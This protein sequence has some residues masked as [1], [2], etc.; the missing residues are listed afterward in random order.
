[1]L[2]R[3]V[4]YCVAIGTIAGSLLRPARAADEGVP[5]E[6]APFSDLV[7]KCEEF[8]KKTHP[9]HWG[10]LWSEDFNK[11]QADRWNVPPE[12]APNLQ[13]IRINAAPKISAETID[14]RACAVLDSTGMQGNYLRLGPMVHDDFAIEF[15]GQAV[16]DAICDLSILCTSL[17]RGPAFQFG[18]T[19]NTRNVL[20]Y[21]AEGPIP[22]QVVLADKP[23]IEKGRWYTVRLEVKKGK[24]RGLVDGKLFGEADS[25]ARPGRTYRA[26]IYCHESK[27]A[28]DSFR[29]ESM[30]KQQLPNQADIDAV[31]RDVFKELTRDQINQQLALLVDRLEDRKFPV[32]DMAG[33]ML[34]SAGILAEQKLQEAA[35]SGLPETNARATEILSQIRAPQGESPAPATA[36][37]APVRTIEIREH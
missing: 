6:L 27:I 36:P 1:M 19:N 4:L 20:W 31:F 21:W 23:F 37:V 14:K 18:A 12:E 34:R 10:V 33:K 29:I 17:A 8:E 25:A 24:V 7:H 2:I 22:K 30:V 15:V 9:L 13:R 28:I 26:T 5:E 35:E 11:E 3:R 16:G 32:R